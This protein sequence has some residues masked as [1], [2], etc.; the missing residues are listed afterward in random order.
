MDKHCAYL[1]KLLSAAIRGG[2]A[3]EPDFEPVDWDKVF[4]E[5]AAHEVHTLIYPV[6]NR[7]A[8]RLQIPSPILVKW[9]KICLLAAV[10]QIPYINEALRVLETLQDSRIAVIILKGLWLREL[11]PQPELRTMGDIDI[12]VKPS[13]KES[14]GL[15]IKRSGYFGIEHEGSVEAFYKPNFLH[16]ELHY[17]LSSAEEHKAL[18]TFE[19][20]GMCIALCK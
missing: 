13:D 19:R 18:Y 15:L 20:R 1:L 16:I 17:K 7:L 3:P 6:I 10:K 8:S 14:A 2:V 11:Y 9:K 4:T 12:L 5:A